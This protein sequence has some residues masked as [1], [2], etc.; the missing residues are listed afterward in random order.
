MTR[1][2]C[3]GP[4]ELADLL[5][6]RLGQARCDDLAA[7][8]DGCPACQ[9]RVEAVD[10][11]PLPVPAADAAGDESDFTGEDACREVIALLEATDPASLVG[12]DVPD[13]SDAPPRRA[14]PYELEEEIGRGGMGV[15][16][17][18]RDPRLD[19]TVAVKM[20]RRDLLPT[21][22][23]VLRFRGEAAAAAGLDHPNIVPIYEVGGDDTSPYFAMALVPGRS[24]AEV[25][26]EGPL[27]P[28]E[29]AAHVRTVA[30]AVAYAHQRGVVHRDLKPANLLLD[31][32][33]SPRVSDFGVAKRTDVDSDLTGTGFLVGTPNYMPPE[34]A[35]GRGREV[36]PRADV[37]ALGAT[38]YCLVT[39]HPPFQAATKLEVV[40]QVLERD[41]V[42]PRKVNRSVPRDLETVCLKCLEKSPARRYHDA[43]ELADDLGRFLEDR[44]IKAQPAGPVTVLWRG[45]RRRPLVAALSGALAVVGLVGLAGV[46][47]EWR[48][49]DARARSERW[50]RYRAE[51]RAASTLL[52]TAN[53]SPARAALDH[54]PEEHRGWEWRY[55]S[56]R[57]DR[58]TATLQGHSAGI[59]SL[60]FSPDGTRLVSASADNS[61]IVWALPSGHR[62]ATLVGHTHTPRELHFAGNDRLISTSDDGTLRLWDLKAPPGRERTV[63]SGPESPAPWVA[64]SAD[65]KRVASWRGDGTVAVRDTAEGRL[66]AEFGRGQPFADSLAMSPDGRLLAACLD[67]GRLALCDASGRGLRTV[68]TGLERFGI[69]FSP[70][71]R[72]VAACHVYP[73]NAITWYDS[74]TGDRLGTGLGHE[75]EV[76]R[77]VFS[78]DGAVLASA[79]IDQTIRLWDAATG[80]LRSVLRGHTGAV[81]GLEFSPDGRRLVTAATDQVPRLWDVATGE[82]VA[83]LGG[84][85]DAATA[86]AYSGD[87]RYIATGSADRTVR[88]WDVA[89][90]ERNGILRGHE[91]FVYDVAWAPDGSRLYSCGWDGTVRTWDPK[92]ERE[93]GQARLPA[94]ILSGLSVRPDGRQVAVVR[95]DDRVSL[96]PADLHGPGVDLKQPTGYWR[97]RP[98]VAFDPAGAHLLAGGYGGRAF[99]WD[100]AAQTPTPLS[101]PDQ[102]WH[103]A[104]AVRPDGRLAAVGSESGQITLWEPA[105]RKVLATF[106]GHSS[107]VTALRFSPDGTR[108]AS[109]SED[110]SVRLWDVARRLSLARMP[111]G[112]IVHGLAFSPDGT[113]LA[114]AC[115][116][117]TI[118]IWDLAGFVRLVELRGHRAYVHAV[119][120]SP[121]GSFLAS[122]SGDRT[123]RL[124]STR[125]GGR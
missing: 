84:H 39:G 106:G 81:R 27:P 80:R 110:N 22:E 59:A 107:L 102:E 61:M 20:L 51:M 117:N 120:F 101:Q 62:L 94:P 57:L 4:S 54:A 33:G 19:R 87:G 98:D 45:V 113:R 5:A 92:N 41:P 88:L 85:S 15:V 122:A 16:Y 64:A 21:H 48:E 71:G 72:L 93:V 100:L 65:G 115:G 49:A 77:V 89:A 118:G 69:T 1:T 103:T 42:P 56:A 60:L 25:V 111:H 53:M 23:D 119:A 50:E 17:R 8:I 90:L 58:A 44:P 34:Q 123:V 35:D 114:S 14:G 12:R 30:L 43:T 55:L 52:D 67:R 95:N 104:V 24:L 105:A 10:A 38:L 6:G 47:W 46:V 29:A 73:S 121:D 18:A 40:R 13:A 70:D 3:P 99:L 75:N 91:S 83:T 11:T 37:Y 124:W 36:G 9:A 112:G 7:H 76:V 82:P 86:V 28:R 125:P 66:L 2:I 31:P 96:L 74:T 108:L 109:A 63:V 97:R 78:P 32:E 116:D 68:D 26:A 79:S